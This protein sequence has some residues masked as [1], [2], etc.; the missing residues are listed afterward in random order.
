MLLQPLRPLDPQQRHQ[1]EGDQCRPQPV[2]HRA[3]AAVHLPGRVQHTA[4]QQGGRRQQHAGPGHPRAWAEDRGRVVEHPHAREQPIRAPVGRVPVRRRRRRIVLDRCDSGQVWVR[5]QP[6]ILA[7]RATAIGPVTKSLLAGLRL[8]PGRRT[9]HLWV[10]TLER[11]HALGRRSPAQSPQRL[12]YRLLVDPEPPRDLPGRHPFGLQPADRLVSRYCHPRTPFRVPTRPT[13]RRQP[14]RN[15]PTLVPPYRPDVAPERER[16][17]GLTG[18]PLPHQG[19]HGVRLRQ[20]VAFL[21]VMNRKARHRDHPLL[22]LQPQATTP[23]D[24]DD[25]ATANHPGKQLSL[26][27]STDRHAPKSA[28]PAPE[29][30]QVLVRNPQNP[31]PTPSTT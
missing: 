5:T 26:P 20:P 24:N 15:E 3:E 31:D 30:G 14:T 8:D 13:Q 27:T 12:S 23:V 17:L 2:E 25:L 19:H 9:G 1:E 29:T 4:G 21:V 22:P 18:V 11:Q 28:P 16:D 10:R 7:G 6:A